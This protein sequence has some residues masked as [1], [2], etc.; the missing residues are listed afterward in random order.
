MPSANKWAD[1]DRQLAL[2]TCHHEASHAVVAWRVG[3]MASFI[4]LGSIHGGDGDFGGMSW[5]P[6]IYDFD[7]VGMIK[8]LLL[9]CKRER[10]PKLSYKSALI[11]YA[12][13]AG[14][15]KYLSDV[16]GHKVCADRSHFVG[17]LNQVRQV[18]TDRKLMAMYRKQADQMVERDWEMIQKLAFALFERKRMERSEIADL[19][20]ISIGRGGQTAYDFRDRAPAFLRARVKGA[21]NA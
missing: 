18:T 15:N 16:V 10:V 21:R 4:Q 14:H 1:T 8:T 2:A 20:G 7:P 9:P 11:A 6:P 3:E 19:L 5:I 12:G 13:R 17:D